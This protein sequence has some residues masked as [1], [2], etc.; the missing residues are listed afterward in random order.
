MSVMLGTLTATFGSSRIASSAYQKW[1]TGHSHSQFC[2]TPIKRVQHL[3]HFKFEN[4]LR[5][6]RPQYF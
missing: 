5:A 1:P 4:K 2:Q 6:F 3:T